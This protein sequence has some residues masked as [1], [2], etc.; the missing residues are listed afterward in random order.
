MRSSGR[1]IRYFN[2]ITGNN[3][4]TARSSVANRKRLVPNAAKILSTPMQSDRGTPI[5]RLRSAMPYERLFPFRQS[6][7]RQIA[8]ILDL[9][10]EDVRIGLIQRLD[11]Q[12]AYGPLMSKN[13][14]ITPPALAQESSLSVKPGKTLGRSTIVKSHFT[15]FVE[16]ADT[17]EDIVDL[18]ATL[19]NE[20]EDED[21]NPFFRTIGIQDAEIPQEAADEWAEEILEE[22]AES[23]EKG[24]EKLEA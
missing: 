5:L 8:G 19:L 6:M 4:N 22:E 2:E 21:R 3:V 14:E 1:P 11:H 20:V 15:V 12:R 23:L 10:E 18:T 16:N 24:E 17:L 9:A 7:R 13:T